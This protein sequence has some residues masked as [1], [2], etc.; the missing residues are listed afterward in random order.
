MKKRSTTATSTCSTA[1][2]DVRTSWTHPTGL[3]FGEPPRVPPARFQPQFEALSWT[4]G[5]Q[6]DTEAAWVLDGEGNRSACQLRQNLAQA[7]RYLRYA[8]QPRRMWID[9]ICI[10]QENKKEQG[11]QVLRMKDIYRLADR[12]VIWL[13]PADPDTHLAFEGLRKLGARVEGIRSLGVLP[14]PIYAGEYPWQEG[15]CGLAFSQSTWAALDDLFARLWFGRVWTVQESVLA[16]W[17][18]AFQCGSSTLLSGSFW[19]GCGSLA[20]FSTSAPFNHSLLRRV[21]R[22]GDLQSRPIQRIMLCAIEMACSDPRDKIYG[23]LGLMP[24]NMKG[25]IRPNYILTASQVLTQ[26]VIQHGVAIRRLGLLNDCDHSVKLP[27]AP[28]WS[29]N[30]TINQPWASPFSLGLRA[31]GCFSSYWTSNIKDGVLEVEGVQHSFVSEA[32]PS[33]GS[34]RSMIDFFWRVFQGQVEGVPKGVHAREYTYAYHGGRLED[35]LPGSGYPTLAQ[36]TSKML[37]ML[38]STTDP[39]VAHA[40]FLKA[41]HAPFPVRVLYTDGGLAGVSTCLSVQRGDVIVVIAG[42]RIPKILRPLSPSATSHNT[43]YQLVGSCDILALSN[44]EAFLG[45]LPKAYT[46]R[47]LRDSRG[48]RHPCFIND[49]T[50]A[51]L[52]PLEDPRLESLPAEWNTRELSGEG[53]ETNDGFPLFEFVHRETGE[54]TRIDPRCT[55]EALIARGIKLETFVL[56]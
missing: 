1:G 20:R 39:A 52:G 41:N 37:E 11:D 46:V 21:M 4:W 2:D 15:T 27:D 5:D 12:V 38:T 50:G 42:C 6:L 51:W 34:D 32:S 26:A 33:L 35:L 44:A 16:N 29:P 24:R 40:S 28:S 45:P 13:G 55:R 3:N 22:R 23:V 48:E 7:I 36:A 47:Y 31:S 18:S 19:K 17:D 14:P 30:Y 54:A 56:R 53:D 25:D 8:G 43:A 9:N 10:N 49:E